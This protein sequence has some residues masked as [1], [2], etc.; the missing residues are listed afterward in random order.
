MARTESTIEVEYSSPIHPALPVEVM[1]RR[2]LPERASGGHFAGRQRLWFHVLVLCTEGE[3]VHHI[4]FKPVE[5]RPGTLVHI[6]PGQFQRFQFQPNFDALM[7]VYQP[8][9]YRTFIPGSEWFPGSDVTTRWDLD[10]NDM[11]IVTGAIE[12]LVVEQRAFDGSPARIAL[13]ESLLTALLARLSLLGSVPVPSRSFPEPYLQFRRYLEKNLDT[14]PT[15][16]ACAKEIGY[17][18]RTLD[19]ACQEAVGLT[20]KQVLNRRMA[21]EIR[22]L[23][24][25]TDVPVANVGTTLGFT[26]ASSFA[27][28][29]RRHLGAS[30]TELREQATSTNPK[31]SPNPVAHQLPVLR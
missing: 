23:L 8:D 14:R 9:L 10:T 7:V 21:L 19:R 13:L 5:F 16:T 25:G 30:P 15:V 26:E 2:A 1:T 4:D 28:F 18:T 20:A 29:V 31:P 11:R 22:R 12:E 17:S 3:G 27:K 6:H 24:S